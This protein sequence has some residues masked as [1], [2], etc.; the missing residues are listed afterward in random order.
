MQRESLK[1]TGRTSTE[2]ETCANAGDTTSNML[3]SSA[4]GSPARTL[5]TPG[6]EQESKEIVADC[7]PSSI[8]SFASYDPVTS[9]WRTSQLCL[10]GALEEF[11]E[12]W[13][14]AGMTR[15]GTAFLL[16]PSVPDSFVI[17]F[18]SLRPPERW[19]TPNASRRGV[20]LDTRQRSSGGCC[21]LE[22]DVALMGDIGPLN[23]EWVEW[24]MGFGAGWTESVSS[25]TP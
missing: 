9:S 18:S 2:S 16:P 23:P 8:G 20:W 13:P 4:A 25:A 14:R 3:T 21:T 11:S 19:T 12:T 15:N 10:D 22:S 17:A 6:S 24:L 5:A 7:G 1:S